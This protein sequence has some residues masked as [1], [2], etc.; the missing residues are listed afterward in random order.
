MVVTSEAVENYNND[1]NKH[2]LVGK[3]HTPVKDDCLTPV[4]RNYNR[5]DT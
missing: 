1:E 5:V 3:F 4:R 2:K